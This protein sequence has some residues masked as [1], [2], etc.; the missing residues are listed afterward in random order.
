MKLRRGVLSDA[1]QLS[2]LAMRAKASWGYP[3]AWLRAWR[4]Q[5]E[6][7][8]S[9]FAECTVLVAEE[10]SR[11]LGVVAFAFDLQRKRGEIEH[12]WV[13]PS[14]HRRGLGRALLDATFAQARHAGITSLRVESDPGAR[15]FYE[16][17]G[18]TYEGEVAAPVLDVQ[19][20]LPVLQFRIRRAGRESDQPPG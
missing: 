4:P 2:D 12:L 16:K 9:V 10:E 19:R 1:D 5:L 20:S 8:P 15:P 13:D 6:F 18:A 17:L 3:E 11:I 14:A 7:T